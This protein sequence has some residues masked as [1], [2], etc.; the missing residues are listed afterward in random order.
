MERRRMED[1]MRLAHEVQL[2][3]L[4]DAP[5][6]L[7]GYDIAGICIPT[8][9]IGGDYFDFIP[10]DDDRL[11]LVV[12][13]V[14][15]KGIPAALNM[16]SFRSLI[17]T[18][19]RTRPEP[20]HL[21]N[22]VNELLPEATGETAYVTCV[23]AILGRKEGRLVYTNCGHN[24]PLVVRE[25]GDIERLE[26]GGMPLG[27]FTDSRYESG[28]TSLAPADLVVFYTDGV[29]ESM[30]DSEADFGIDRLSA[31]IQGAR[32]RSALDVIGEVARA[33]QAFTGRSSHADD[34]TVMVVRR[35]GS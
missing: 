14:S 13:D 1:Q 17:R 27:L 21:A 18:H 35:T 5:P 20:S 10:I 6:R 23:Y 11:G 4:P 28:E 19:A 32:H 34:F 9:D 33:T 30:D 7:P 24:P 29:V 3:L 16:T 22:R 15:G 26:Q 8:F 25:D 2:R 12:A 31:V